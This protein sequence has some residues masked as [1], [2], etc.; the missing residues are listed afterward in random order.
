MV[1]RRPQ[2][3]RI[4]EEIWKTTLPRAR[5]CR[6]DNLA[7]HAERWPDGAACAN[8]ASHIRRIVNRSHPI[9]NLWP[10]WPSPS[11]EGTASLPIKLCHALPFLV[12]YR[13]GRT[14]SQQWT[15]SYS[16]LTLAIEV[17]S[18]S[19]KSSWT[20]CSQ[21]NNWPT[22]LFLFLATKSTVLVR[23]PRM[24]WGKFS[25]F[26]DRRLAKEKFRDQSCTGGPSSYLCAPFS[27]VK[28]TAKVFAGLPSI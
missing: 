18:T 7:S 28:D 1:H 2:L 19:P 14:T 20:P 23:P 4:M 21:T 10:G 11:A 9:H 16:W 22:A 17:V 24:S 6:Q 26:T 12:F 15:R 5:Q 8:V 3:P 25:A 13:C 27:N